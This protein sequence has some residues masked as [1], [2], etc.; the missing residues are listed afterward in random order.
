MTNDYIESVWWGLRQIWDQGR[1]YNAHKVVPYCPRDGTALSSREVAQGYRDV[2][3]PS[4][5]VKLPVTTVP[6]ADEIP[7]RPLRPGDSLPV[8]TPTPW[9]LIPD[10]AEAA[11]PE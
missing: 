6:P 11:G 2:L 3:D 1:L 9:A 10:A 8:G 7:E 4:V 5:Y